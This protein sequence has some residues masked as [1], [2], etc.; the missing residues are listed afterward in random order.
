[1]LLTAIVFGS[2][3]GY[4]RGVLGDNGSTERAVNWA[5]KSGLL[6]ILLVI[7][8]VVFGQLEL[9]LENNW[10]IPFIPSFAIMMGFVYAIMD[11]SSVLLKIDSG[12]F[13][14]TVLEGFI[15][16]ILVGGLAATLIQKT[17]NTKVGDSD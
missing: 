16:G 2:L 14:T 4:G 3:L 15:G 5:I 10:Q 1:M 11:G 17:E 7:L 13:W 8:S 9:F 6:G 12:G